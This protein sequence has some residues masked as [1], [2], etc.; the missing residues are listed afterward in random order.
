MVSPACLTVLV[1]GYVVPAP[2]KDTS[3]S[4]LLRQRYCV[5]CLCLFPLLLLLF[6]GAQGLSRALSLGIIAFQLCR[7][8]TRCLSEYGTKREWQ[9]SHVAE[10]NCRFGCGVAKEEVKGGMVAEG[11]VD[12]RKKGGVDVGAKPI[13]M[14]EPASPNL[15]TMN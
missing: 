14:S 9:A 10:Q 4:D 11:R 2:Q 1:K 15:V 12:G 5:S 7:S 3:K 6:S 8:V 13:S